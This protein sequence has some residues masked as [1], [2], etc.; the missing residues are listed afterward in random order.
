[1]K[2][3]VEAVR[4]PGNFHIGH[5]GFQDIVQRMNSVGYQLD[6]SFKINHLS[7][8]AM[9]NFERIANMFPDAGVMHPLDDYEL[10]KPESNG[11]MKIGFNL[12][13]VPA[14]FVGDIIAKTL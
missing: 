6:N 3:F 10:I 12:K 9:E 14:I 13:A 11:L 1:M 4:V 7:F 8:G 2:G 5:H